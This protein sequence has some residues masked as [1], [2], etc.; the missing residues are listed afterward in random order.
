MVVGEK[1]ISKCVGYVQTLGIMEFGVGLNGQKAMPVENT[2]PM[3][4]CRPNSTKEEC[5][6]I[7]TENKDWLSNT[8]SE[9][10]ANHA[11]YCPL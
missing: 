2:C 11:V 3:K 1:N 8:V 9:V 6:K 5:G 4:K 10:R 7:K